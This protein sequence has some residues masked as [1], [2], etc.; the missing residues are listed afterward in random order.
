MYLK[1]V[2]DNEIRNMFG[3]LRNMSP[4]HDGA[5]AHLIR[6]VTDDMVAQLSYIFNLS[7]QCGGFPDEIS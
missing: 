2:E 5:T 1:P 3:D 7:L 4:T 6:N